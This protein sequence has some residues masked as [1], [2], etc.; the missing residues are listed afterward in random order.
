MNH[1]YSLI[2]ITIVGIGIGY[3]TAGPWQIVP[4]KFANKLSVEQ[5]ETKNITITNEFGVPVMTLKTIEMDKG[6]GSGILLKS[7]NDNEIVIC[8][9]N[10]GMWF[11]MG[12]HFQVRI[13]QNGLCW[14][15]SNKLTIFNNRP[16]PS[17]LAR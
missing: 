3:T 6:G 7:P 14:I 10:N 17:S 15:T 2:L 11:K 13:E 12:E 5:I 16:V 4:P 9:S 1:K 8:V